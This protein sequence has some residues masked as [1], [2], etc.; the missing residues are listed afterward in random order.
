MSVLA[1]LEARRRPYNGYDDPSFPL[2]IW[3]GQTIVVGD[4]SGGTRVA[5]VELAP[6]SGPKVSLLWSL[7]QISVLDTDNNSKNGDLT[8]T[9]LDELLGTQVWRLGLGDGVG[10]ASIPFSLYPELPLWAGGHA[11]QGGQAA[12]TFTLANIDA[13]VMVFTIQG[14]AWGSRSRSLP[15][16]PQRPPRG[17]FRP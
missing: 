15:G 10:T 14:Y 12:I 1:T 11:A 8:F 5:S 7:E 17:I 2:Y 6:A 13:T 16:G 3:A 4:A 9:G